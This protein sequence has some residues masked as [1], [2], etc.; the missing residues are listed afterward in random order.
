MGAF[1][2]MVAEVVSD[3]KDRGHPDVTATLEFALAA[4]A[5]GAHDASALGRSLGV[6]KQAA[7]KTITTLE[8]LGYVHRESDPKDARRKVLA[9]TSRGRDMTAIGAAR[10]DELRRRWSDAIGAQR[11]EQVEAALAVLA[12]GGHP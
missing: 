3:L 11:V 5:D 10:F 8:Q 2:A 7:A 12:D 4:I 1:D 6:S 9:V